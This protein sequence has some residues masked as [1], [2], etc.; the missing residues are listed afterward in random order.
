MTRLL[1][2]K[3]RAP[4][5]IVYTR[6]TLILPHV[7]LLGNSSTSQKKESDF[8]FECD[9]SKVKGLK[10]VDGQVIITRQMIILPRSRRGS[11]PSIPSF[12]ISMSKLTKRSLESGQTSVCSLSILVDTCAARKQMCSP[13][14]L[15]IYSAHA[16]KS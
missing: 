4:R 15:M 14:P 2:E 8:Q 10:K 3:N 7:S 12:P 13:L 1:N 16:R 6:S 11:R 9:R 5:I